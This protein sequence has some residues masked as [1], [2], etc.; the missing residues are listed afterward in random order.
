MEWRSLRLAKPRFR[1]MVLRRYI[2]MH[3]RLRRCEP[4]RMCEAPPHRVTGNG[5]GGGGG[6]WVPRLGFND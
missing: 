4:L 2:W 1:G 5:G 6:G 3:A